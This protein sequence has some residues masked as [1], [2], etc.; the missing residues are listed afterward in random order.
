MKPAY[1]K[2]AAELDGIAQ[3]AEVDCTRTNLCN[4]MGIRSYPSIFLY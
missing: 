1:R 3:V 2:L 4:Q